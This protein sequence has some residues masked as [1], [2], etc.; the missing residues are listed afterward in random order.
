MLTPTKQSKLLDALKKYSKKYLNANLNELDESG[1][2]I[3]INTFLSDVLGYAPIEE[4][5]TEYMIRGTYADYVVQMK[6]LTFS[7]RMDKM[8]ASNKVHDH[9]IVALAKVIASF[10]SKAEIISTTTTIHEK[11][12]YPH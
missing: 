2:R 8:L 7:R 5:K 6:R 12:K 4:I 3:M 10:H 11:V 9:H 1:T